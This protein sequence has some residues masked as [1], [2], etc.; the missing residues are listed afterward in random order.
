V[1]VRFVDIGTIEIHN[2][3]KTNQQWEE[4]NSF[5]LEFQ[6][7][8]ETLYFQNEQKYC[9][10]KNDD[11]NHVLTSPITV[12]SLLRKFDSID[13]YDFPTLYTTL[14]HKL[15]KHKF[16]YL[17]KWSFRKSNCDYICCNDNISFCQ[18]VERLLEVE[19]DI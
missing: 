12:L 11:I 14:P 1:I 13:S 19:V 6:Q 4:H 17:I 18:V 2:C 8:D 5:L 15:I 7:L 16:S 3:S 9:L 10:G